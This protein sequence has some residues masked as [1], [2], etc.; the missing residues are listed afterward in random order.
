MSEGGAEEE[1]G[2]EGLGGTD[3]DSS[4]SP[5]PAIAE[6]VALAA[7]G[8]DETVGVGMV[9]LFAEETDVDVD[10]VTHL[11]GGVEV[12][13]VLRVFGAGDGA[14]GVEGEV[15]RGCVLAGAR[16]RSRGRRDGHGGGRCR[17]RDRRRGWRWCGYRTCGG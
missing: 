12:V 5:T 9:E 10:D 13:D 6:D 15:F 16:G 8:V 17:L 14:V 11:N 3:H 7:A 2:A 4:A 1:A